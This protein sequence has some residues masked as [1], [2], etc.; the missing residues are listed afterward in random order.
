MGQGLVAGQFGRG[1]RTVVA[2]GGEGQRDLI[3]GHQIGRD[4]GFGIQRPG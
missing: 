1:F 3:A 2:V 4:K